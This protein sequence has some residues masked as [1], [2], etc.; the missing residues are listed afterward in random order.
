MNDNHETTIPGFIRV[1]SQPNRSF[2]VRA[3]LDDMIEVTTDVPSTTLK[4]EGIPGKA[5]ESN[6]GRI[7]APTN[8]K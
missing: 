7:T 3:L 2:I 1:L 5:N 6:R 4:I 8:M